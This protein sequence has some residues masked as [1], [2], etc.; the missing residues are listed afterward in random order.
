MRL[1]FTIL[2]LSFSLF[3]S[4]VSAQKHQDLFDYYSSKQIENLEL[5]IKQLEGSGNNDPELQFFRAV[6]SDNGDNAFQIY[7]RLFKQSEGPLKNLT[8]QKLAEYYYARGFYIRSSE[9]EK[10]AKTYIPVKTTESVKTG[11]NTNNY[12]AKKPTTPIYQIQVGA[13]GVRKNADDLARFLGNKKLRVS[14]VNR[15][16]DGTDLFCVWVEGKSNLDDTEKVANEIK[17]KYSL[18]YRIIKP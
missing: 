2:I 10:I 6:I 15:E 12:K 7:E 8:A 13:F 16:V 1:I 3:N 11:D 18:S 17:K 5:R 9:Y 14:V 4:I